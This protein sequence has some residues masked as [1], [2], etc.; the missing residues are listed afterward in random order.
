MAKYFSTR[1]WEVEVEMCKQ[2]CREG[3]VPCS[4]DQASGKIEIGRLTYVAPDPDRCA[5]EC[6]KES[7]M[8]DDKADCC[9]GSDETHSS[10]Y[11]IKIARNREIL[12]NL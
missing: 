8:C 9:D 5:S 4:N 6:V 11:E 2:A 3:F 12:D 1:K 7:E 10:C